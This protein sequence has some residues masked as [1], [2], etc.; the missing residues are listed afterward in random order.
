MMIEL[1]TQGGE[2]DEAFNLVRYTPRGFSHHISKRHPE[3]LD[4]RGGCSQ[5]E[6]SWIYLYMITCMKERMYSL[7]LQRESMCILL[8]YLLRGMKVVA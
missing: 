6:T 7:R 2:H 4:E 3:M 8:Y 1:Q 5:P